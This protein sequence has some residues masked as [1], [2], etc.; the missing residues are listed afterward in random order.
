MPKA[1]VGTPKYLA[2]K[3]K[4]KGLQKLR[5]YCQMCQK[6]CR[7]ENGFKCHTMSEAHQRQLLLFA[8]QPN[9]FLAD[10]SQDFESGFMNLLKRAHS[11]KRVF[12]NMVYQEYIRE[13][14]HIHMNATRWE[15]LSGFIQYLGRTGK[16]TVDRTEKG[17][18]IAWIDRDPET[19][20]RQEALAKKDKMAKDDEE[21]LAAFISK[22]VEKGSSSS[23]SAEEDQAKATELMRLSEDEK[24]S[25][26]FM[27]TKQKAADAKPNIK[28][29]SFKVPESRSSSNVGDKRDSESKRKKS[30]LDEIMEAELLAAKKKRLASADQEDKAAAADERPW[31][32]KGIVVKVVTKSL[33]E[34]YYKAKGHVVEVVGDDRMGAV[35]QMAGG[36]AKV[37]VDQS[38]LE[39]VVPAPDRAV[40][41][42]VGKHRGREAVLRDLDVDNFCARLKLVDTGEKLS[43]PYEHFS[44]LHSS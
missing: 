18:Y 13:K 1:E 10:F 33:G 34:K 39:T 31:L 20:A 12:S 38:H 8:D 16:C 27:T 17:W 6:Q 29:G 19:I 3:M 30:A 15:T 36:G 41:I 44:K 23:A 4:S 32:K 35:V 42:L 14:D 25:L 21:R 28:L 43:L 37:K 40:L 5:W 11:T 2:N 24:V 7:D 26:N 9:K 22:Q